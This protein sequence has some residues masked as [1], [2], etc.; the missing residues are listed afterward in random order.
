MLPRDE[1]DNFDPGVDPFASRTAKLVVDD[2]KPAFSGKP[3]LSVMISTWNRQW[4]LARTLECL[5]R[6]EWREFEVLV[7]DDGSTQ[8]LVPIFEIF[9]PFLQLKVFQMD[10]N[11]WRSCPSRAFCY[12]LPETSGEVIVIT[13]PEMML[14]F[15]AV[16]SLY[17]GCTSDE[18]LENAHYYSLKKPAQLTGE[19]TWMSLKP[20]FINAGLYSFLDYVN[21]HK[22]VKKIW[23]LPGFLEER[24]FSGKANSV[25]ITWKE[26]PWWFVGAAKRACPIWDDMPITDGHGIVDMWLISYREERNFIEIT[27]NEPSCLHQPHQI[28]AIAPKGEQVSVVP[29]DGPVVKRQEKLNV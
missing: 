17:Q 9:A 2:L 23:E 16:Y 18:P 22:D 20:Q 21:W 3:K 14:H 29:G 6:Q 28:S 11:S 12:M 4:Q 8:D 5:A 13:H 15:D 26:Y 24:G 19:W 25:H 27:P 1:F 10:R 7:M